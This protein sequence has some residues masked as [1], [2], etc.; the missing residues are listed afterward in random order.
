MGT[1]ASRAT[2]LP[3]SQ[4]DFRER[5]VWASL[6]NGNW[7]TLVR[8]R[9]V[10]ATR[11]TS[12]GPAPMAAA[13]RTRYG[14]AKFSLAVASTASAVLQRRA[15]RRP[16][17]CAT[18]GQAGLAIPRAPPPAGRR[19]PA[20]GAD[21]TPGPGEPQGTFG[22]SPAC[23]P[24]GARRGKTRPGAGSCR[25]GRV[26]RRGG[27]PHA[28]KRSPQPDSVRPPIARQ[29]PAGWRPQPPRLHPQRGAETA[30]AG[31]GTPR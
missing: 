28:I 24:G 17:A 19:A 1:H 9:G 5:A 2:A 4:R 11:L 12:R 14:A 3:A 25:S 8:S 7:R 16:R 18:H 31:A 10:A 13:K 15:R 27:R 23:E 30:P 26:R 6:P 20:G 22:P 21:L 29:P